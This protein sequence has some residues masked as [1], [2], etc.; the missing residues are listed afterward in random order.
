M[1]GGLKI[2]ITTG[3][4]NRLEFL[5]R[6]LPT[7]LAR[8]EIDEIVIVDF[9]NA[10]PL[11]DS[12]AYEQDPR[13]VYVRVIDHRFWHNSK[14]HNLE[15]R[16]ATGDL[17]LRL[18]NDYILHD[19]FFTKH[20]WQPGMFF[21]GN[22]RSV[23][24]CLDDKRNLAGTLFIPR[25]ALY[26]VNGYNERLNHYG[27]EDDDI[28]HR[29]STVCG[30]QRIDIDIDTMDHIAHSSTRRYENLEIASKLPSLL[31]NEYHTPMWRGRPP[32]ELE[33]SFLI[34]L[35]EHIAKRF[36]WTTLDVMTKWEIQKLS[37][38]RYE[39]W[40]AKKPSLST[41]EGV[42]DSSL[43]SSCPPPTTTGP[44]HSTSR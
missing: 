24:K 35:S 29:L 8:P 2:S 21:A 10:I 26:E 3:S 6:T 9:G 13:I 16:V 17:L 36:P 31:A 30:L 14:C 33:K 32:G 23:P 27:T 1:I 4:L 38:D 22:W 40:E 11:W 39:C 25:Q 42:D 43:K 12:L 37:N 28:Y 34:Q 20:R 7:W 19:D 41:E 18:D 15:F 44:S 5:R